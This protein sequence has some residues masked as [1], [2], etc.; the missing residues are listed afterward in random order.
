M[1]QRMTGRLLLVGFLLLLLC[2]W[3]RAL[4]AQSEQF[5]YLPIITKPIPPPQ[6]L[7]FD[8]NVETADPGDTIELSWATQNAI[9]VTIYHLMASGQ[10]G[11]F[12]NVGITG[13]M[14]YTIS[15][16]ARNIERFHIYAASEV[17]PTAGATLEII[18][19]C[20]FTWFFAPAPDIC[21]QD[22]AL[23]S[24]AA[25]QQ[26]EHGWMI[27]VEEQDFIYVLYDDDIHSPKWQIFQD[28]WDPGE[29]ISDTTIIPPPGHYQP[30][31]GFGLVWREQPNVRDRL[32]WA[33]VEEAGYE[34]AVQRTSY[35]EYNHT[36]LRA[37]DN[38]IWHLFPEQSAWEKFTQEE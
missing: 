3:V 33:V 5:V 13:T 14:T 31:R 15:E 37:L 7:Y 9:T 17:S 34:T 8:A 20:P 27:W 38:D 11:E 26:F 6:I 19:T 4:P 23:I 18:L 25:E 30:L 28:E 21:P 29:P 22:A 24:P 32:G 10:L 16:L 35:Y 1:K 36:Y 12:W 2:Q